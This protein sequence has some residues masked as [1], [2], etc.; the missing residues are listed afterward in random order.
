MRR[1]I[2]LTQSHHL[3]AKE[4][5]EATTATAAAVEI[6]QVRQLAL[7]EIVST[8]SKVV[9]VNCPLCAGALR[10]SAALSFMLLL[11]VVATCNVGVVGSN[12]GADRC[13][14]ILRKL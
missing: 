1:P 12:D 6:A 2:Q 11:D 13:S 10:I 4:A 9:G 3:D 5:K 14:E 7:T 8:K